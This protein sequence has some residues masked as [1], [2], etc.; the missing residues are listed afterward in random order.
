M[1]RRSF[2]KTAGLGLATAPLHAAGTARAQEA[3]PSRPPNVVLVL[4]D[5][6]G[7]G[8]LACHGNPWLKTPNLDA[9]YEQSIR[10][11]DFHVSPL[12]S[13]TRAALLTGRHCRHVGVTGTNNSANF[14]AT[15]VP[16]IASVFAANGY[17]TGHFGKWHLGD[18][19]PYRPH[20]RGFQEAIYHG[21]GAITTVAD[22]DWHNNYFDD[23][24][25]HNG[26]K[27]KFEGYC[28]EV[29]FDEAMRFIESNREA[30]FFC[31]LA[32]N[33][34][35]GPYLVDAK[36]SAP[37]A[38]YGAEIAFPNYYGMIT[39]ID[40][41][42]GRLVAF[43]SE[44]G[45]EEN[46]ILIFMTDNGST[47]NTFKI[48]DEQD[49]HAYR[50]VPVEAITEEGDASP[51]DLAQGY[52]AGMRAQKASA[53]DG[54][55]RVP[56][57]I[58]W[59][60]GRLQ[61]G[62]DVEQ[63]AAHIDVLPTLLDLCGIQPP[64]T[65]ALDGVSL[66]PLLEDKAAAEP[67]RTVV[68]SFSGTVLTERWRL[69]HDTELYDIHVDPKQLHDL[70]GE[71]PDVVRTLQAEL[72]RSRDA[73]D[74]TERRVIVGSE[75]ED[76]VRF[77]TEQWRGGGGYEKRNVL[78]G[79]PMHGYLLVTAAVQGEYEFS[80]LRWP[81]ELNTPISGAIERGKALDIT[82]A[83]VIINGVEHT[84]DVTGDMI[85]ADFTLPLEAGN[86]RIETAFVGPDGATTGAYY[87]YI[88]RK[89]V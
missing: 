30:P 61:G 65:H 7:Y 25:L 11:T 57:F 39:N 77:T 2:I 78:E 20:D 83:R 66:K 56:F 87:I 73:E 59:P 52:N 15:D 13:P 53:Y 64:A 47:G 67:E 40:E 71:H 44:M 85:S 41:N 79:V 48:K 9:L 8:D 1:N 62:R 86:A 63:L 70:A 35:H 37:Y 88:G 68:E 45:L 89:L 55:H 28:T 12:C 80:L 18:S 32:T 82:Q 51:A 38:K 34:P 36:Y 6:Q 76:P 16:T 74:K 27:Q 84:Q 21:N 22:A 75:Q 29:W 24:Y 43:L 60:G 14:M 81:K 3:K 5:D 4:T 23:T 50:P 33:A 72:K 26:Q 49:P 17:R 54:G 69:V 42:M 31:Y 58:R 19:Y 46:T 10:F